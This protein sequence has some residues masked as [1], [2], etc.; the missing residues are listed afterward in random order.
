MADREVVTGLKRGYEVALV[1]DAHSTFTKPAKQTIEKWQAEIE[2]A[3]AIL[4]PAD[5][6]IF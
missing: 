3:G 6:V 5:E 4:T 1:S 2:K